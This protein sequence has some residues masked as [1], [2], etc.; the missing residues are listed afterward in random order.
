M[1]QSTLQDIESKINQMHDIGLQFVNYKDSGTIVVKVV[2]KSTGK[3]IR[4]IPSEDFLNM[5]S[6]MNQMIG[7]LFDKKV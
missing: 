7:I 2:D 5:V 4:E 3:V 1:N 6:A